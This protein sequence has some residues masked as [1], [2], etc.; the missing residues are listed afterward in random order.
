MFIGAI[1]FV[2][3]ELRAAEPLLPFGLLRHRVFV[4]GNLVWLLGCLMSWGTVFFVA[5]A[6][7]TMLGLRPVLAGLALTPIY[8]VMMVGAP[9]AGR[10][11][12]R[13]GARVPI[14]AGLGVSIAG[15]LALSAVGPGSSLVPDVVA[16]ILVF[17]TG[18]A[19]FT[20]PLA[21]V[22]MGALDE[23]DQGVASGVNN[24]AGQLAGLLAIA[25]LPPLAGLSGAMVGGPAF[26][27]GY[28]NALRWAA[29][30]AGLAV[31]VTIWTLAS[32]KSPS[33]SGAR[34]AN[35]AYRWAGI[36]GRRPSSV[37]A[38]RRI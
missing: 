22:T 16:G 33:G 15:L 1:A 13:V 9:L 34:P 38:S 26:A 10:L 12:E 2:R 24:A 23:A 11:A 25:I 8:L 5:V 36:G 19:L 31:P 37:R 29:V 32:D 35:A 7:Q 4:G 14:L 21:A 6:M 20:A 17:A 18:L 27:D 3:T 30:I 28:T